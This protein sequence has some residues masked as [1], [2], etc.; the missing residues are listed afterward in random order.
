[1]NY[2]SV[3]IVVFIE[4]FAGTIIE[5]WIKLVYSGRGGE[6]RRGAGSARNE[7]PRSDQ[8]NWP[9]QIILQVQAT[10][11]KGGE[12]HQSDY[13]R[14]SNHCH[15]R[16]QR[17]WQDHSLQ[18]PYR[19]DR[20]YVWHRPN[21]RLRCARF[22]RHASNTQHDRSLSAT[23]HPFRST[24]AAR[25]SRVLRRGAWHSTLDDTTWGT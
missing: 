22:Q 15:P 3:T 21:I 7:G 18:H 23:R 13:L 4:I 9:L 12:W 1:M 20:T 2:R 6:S 10:G 25:T 5:R 8:D 17:R 24:D 16:S 11:D 19:P 14:G